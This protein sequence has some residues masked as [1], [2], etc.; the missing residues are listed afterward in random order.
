MTP[1]FFGRSGEG[2]RPMA[3]KIFGEDDLK[4]LEQ[5]IDAAV[6]RLFVEKGKPT[7]KTSSDPGAIPSYSLDWGRDTIEPSKASSPSAPPKPSKSI[8]RLES[9]LLSLE[10]DIN[11]ESIGK[12]LEEVHILQQEFGEVPE[13]SSLLEK[14]V[15]ILNLMLRK[16]PNIRPTLVRLLLD[17]METLKL[18]MKKDGG[19]EVRIYKKLAQAGIE[20]RFSCLEEFQELKSPTVAPRAEEPIEQKIHPGSERWEE[21]FKKIEALTEKLDR[22]TEKMERHLNDH[23]KVG[24]GKASWP[25]RDAPP[26][27]TRV[28]VF[29]V[30]DQ[31]FGVES[32]RVMNLLKAPSTFTRKMIHHQTFRFKGFDVRWIDLE[33]HFQLSGEDRDREK[34]LLILKEDQEV[35]AIKIDKVIGRLYGPLERDMGRGEYV[36]GTMRWTYEDLPIKIPILDLKR[37]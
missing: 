20:A 32:R 15:A 4:S 13:I 3:E 6:D 27:K 14:M 2:E 36:L 35:K 9:Q 23:S 30:G 11:R 37:L 28:T 25:G 1:G 7:L 10:W 12:S 29:K 26:L 8:D 19:E 31:L 22:L 33:T 18:Q 21:I 34:Q 24:E 5:E 16:E 17:A